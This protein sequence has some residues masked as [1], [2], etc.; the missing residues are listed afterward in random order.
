MGWTRTSTSSTTDEPPGTPAGTA[1]SSAST[2]GDDLL[3]VGTVARP[4]G[5]EGAVVVALLTNRTERLDEGSLLDADGRDLRVVDAKPFGARWLVHFEGVRTR[6]DAERLRGAILRAPPIDDPDAWWVHELI[7]SEV[8]EA[9]SGRR[10]GTVVAVV[11]S[12]A[13]DLLELDDGGL[14]P[15]RFAL[16]RSAGRI[17]VEVPPGL[18]E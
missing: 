1:A 15:L 17:S 2:P 8:V 13:S 6:V 5:V 9:A 14:I 12:P 7:G 11:P 4:H 18:L 16:E 3:E 10:L